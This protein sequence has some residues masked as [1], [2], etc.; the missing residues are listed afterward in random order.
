[1][2]IEKKKHL[3]YWKRHRRS[4]WVCEWAFLYIYERVTMW[5][6]VRAEL[7]DCVKKSLLHL[8][9]CNYLESN[10]NVRLVVRYWSYGVWCHAISELVFEKDQATFLLKKLFFR[11]IFE[12]TL[13]VFSLY[14]KQLYMNFKNLITV[15]PSDRKF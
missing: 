4:E 15:I 12:T 11:Y 6:H 2:L 3:A 8:V 5:C 13:L 1:M 14:L 10:A 7:A 9:L